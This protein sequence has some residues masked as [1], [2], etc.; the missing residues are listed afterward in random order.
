MAIFKGWA[1]NLAIKILRIPLAILPR[2]QCLAI[3]KAIGYL[4]YLLDKPHRRTALKNLK[5]AFG[6]ELNHSQRQHITKAAFCHFGTTFLDVLKIRY[7]SQ[8]KIKNC[9]LVEG[10]EHVQNVLRKGKGAL[11][12]SAHFGNWEL[13]PAFLSSLGKL[14][15]VARALDNPR[16]EKEL[17][18]IRTRLGS[19]VVYKNQAVRQILRA[20]RANEM[21]AILI[22]QNVLRNQAV[23]VDFFGR[24][25]ATTPSLA[26]FFLKA[27]A[28]LIPVF[29]FPTSDWKYHLKIL[30][31]LDISTTGR[32][33]EDVLKITQICTNIIQDQVRQKPNYWFWFHNRWKT[34]P[35]GEEKREKARNESE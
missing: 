14:H 19:R 32:E 30:E 4:V 12:F 3:G 21:V 22:D 13:A 26:T 35:A 24:P 1:E 10:E 18:H 33:Q 34:R 23:F 2:K 15:V 31:P 29:C 7:V 25:A 17:M 16:L 27:E 20:L 8:D 5:T 11:L 9:L 28:P 6:T